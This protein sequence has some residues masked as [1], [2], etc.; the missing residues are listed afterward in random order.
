MLPNQS[1]LHRAEIP[2]LAQSSC[3]TGPVIIT[4]MLPQLLRDLMPLLAGQHTQHTLLQTFP[5]IAETSPQIFDFDV[6]T[7][8]KATQ[9]QPRLPTTLVGKA[10]DVA[11]AGARVTK[12]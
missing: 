11:S 4:T 9:A 1:C 5:F 2:R 10:R 8:H 7:L 3:K 6:P 12:L